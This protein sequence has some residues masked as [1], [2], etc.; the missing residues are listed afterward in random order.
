MGMRFRKSV[1]LGKGTRMNI[2]KS[3][4]GF[5]IGGKGLT[6]TK[7]ADGG[8]RATVSAPG[9]G[10][11]YVK[12]TGENKKSP[13]TMWSG[14]L[15]ALVVFAM[16]GGCSSSSNAPANESS[17]IAESSSSVSS[18]EPG[19]EPEPEKETEIS[20]PE[21][22]KDDE[23]PAIAPVPTPTPEK[24]EQP[25]KQ[26]KP[27]ESGLA[28]SE[29]ENKPA[30]PDKKANEVYITA[31]GTKYHSKPNCGSTKSARS[32]DKDEAERRGYEPCKKCY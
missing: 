21:T 5:S 11:S 7:K 30:T 15:A 32:I 29:P 17:S 16:I 8:T 14:I 22:S 3:G 2:S 4:V 31:S 24:A 20:E 27:V 9:T 28:P 18:V 19:S 10:I 6:L 26:N 1:K 13:G 12:E 25:V 23:V